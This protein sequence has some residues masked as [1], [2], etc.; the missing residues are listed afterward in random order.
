MKFISALILVILLVSG[1]TN[2]KTQVEEDIVQEIGNKDNAKKIESE[3]PVSQKEQQKEAEGFLEQLETTKNNNLEKQIENEKGVIQHQIFIMEKLGLAG[4][5]L[6]VGK[7]VKDDEGK[8][9]AEKYAQ[10]MKNQYS[11]LGIA[12]TVIRDGKE[13]TTVELD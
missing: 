6:V 2:D 4:G 8:R 11:N 13:I 1:C 7:D 5:E 3:S 12:I 10:Q 9:L